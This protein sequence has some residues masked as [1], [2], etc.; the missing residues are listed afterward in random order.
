MG[1][2][3]ARM[4]MVG[5]DGAGTELALLYFFSLAKATPSHCLQF[6]CDRKNHRPVPHETGR[7]YDHYTYHWF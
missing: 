7:A 4:V 6:F 5:L 2:S 1:K 3:T